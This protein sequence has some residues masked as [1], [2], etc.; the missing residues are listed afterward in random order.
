[1][2]ILQGISQSMKNL[3]GS[4]KAEDFSRIGAALA[5]IKGKVREEMQAAT[6][7]DITKILKKLEAGQPLTPEEKDHVGLWVVGDAAGYT[8]ME[9]DFQQWLAEFKRLG[10]A[11]EG[12]EIQ[13][14]SP[15]M[16]VEMHG[17]L[18]DAVRVAADISNFLEK[19]ERVE[20][21]AEAIN[22]LTTDDAKLLADILKS[23]LTRSDM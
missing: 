12:Y 11:L 14:K 6:A 18:E 4:N 15:Q 8:K 5:Q 19:K 21:F 13:E 23:M 3:G 17:L 16:L 1:M 20:R 10:S 2:T 7:G 22:N 9:N